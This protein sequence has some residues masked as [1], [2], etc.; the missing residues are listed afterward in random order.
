[1]SDV[2]TVLVDPRSRL[3]SGVRVAM[4]QRR[5]PVV[6]VE[7]PLSGSVDA[8]AWLGA[9]D[10]PAAYWRS[11][12]GEVE[13]AGLG[14]ADLVTAD[15]AERVLA[16]LARRVA[17]LPDGARY[18]G[19]LRFDD[20]AARAPE[21]DGFGGGRFVLPRFELQ[22]SA[23]AA[24]LAVHV[25]P[26][27]DRGALGELLAEIERLPLPSPQRR[28]SL[29]MPVGRVDVPDPGEWDASVRDVL[30]RIAGGAVDKVVLA[31]RAAYRF[32][33]ELDGAM[34]LRHL[35]EHAP[36]A[37]HVLLDDGAGRSFVAATPER[38]ARVRGRVAET[39]ALAGT[40]RRGEGADARAL[41]DELA[42]SDKD[43][44]EHA[45]VRDAVAERLSPL[46]EV[47]TVGVP[48]Q[49]E[50]ARVR[51]LRTPLRAHL[52]DGVAPLDVVAALHPTPAVGGTPT[53]GALAAIRELEGFDRG[54]YAGPVGWVS[55]DA[56]ELAV[57]IRSGLV[58]GETLQ[59][60]AGA[61]IVPG[62]DPVAEWDETE[63]KLG[64]FAGALGLDLRGSGA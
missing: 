58:D 39:E 51:H 56:A 31:R 28:A 6:R 59:L 41:R 32:E 29:P 61:G 20:E 26:E 37:F 11:R 12:G 10:A 42:S 55:R 40:R 64:A 34:L 15:G 52:A 54:L 27:A 62:S 46:A 36:G 57:G 18:L 48:D 17:E 23:G 8:L 3:A 47:V 22:V 38:L 30:A 4:R 14:V 45:F 5:A 60:Y 25:R 50:S 2:S 7:V 53:P 19:G 44:R 16:Q 21:W 9:S 1:M 49:V 43:R 13:I 35:A 33:E 24:S 63:A